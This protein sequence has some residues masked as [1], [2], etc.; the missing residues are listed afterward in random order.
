MAADGTRGRC[1][2]FMRRQSR[3]MISIDEC[4]K[5]RG[6]SGCADGAGRAAAILQF[7]NAEVARVTTSDCA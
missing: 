1:N 6:T 7:G 2:R 3:N 5:C 4:K